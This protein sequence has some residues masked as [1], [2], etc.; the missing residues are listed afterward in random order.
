M[1]LD[2]VKGIGKVRKEQYEKIGI[3]SA[4]ALIMH[5]PLRY[6]DRGRIL[7]ITD[8]CDGE[9][10]SCMLT[11]ATAP[12]LARLTRGRN[13]VKFRAFDDSASVEI[14]FFCKNIH[15]IPRYEIGER[16][17]VYGRYRRISGSYYTENPICE[18]TDG[19]SEL[20]PLFPIYGL[21]KGLSSKIVSGH[22]R[23][24]IATAKENVCSFF[25]EYLPES[26]LKSE[27]LCT[28]EDAITKLH[29]PKTEKD[30]QV[31]GK[32][33]AF[34]E[35]L[36]YFLMMK[37][38]G[39]RSDT[40]KG[41]SM[42][43]SYPQNEIA[44]LPFSLTEDQKTT[45]E[46]IYRDLSSKF[47]MKRIVI[48]DVG[49]GKTAI[50]QFAALMVLRSG[51][52]VALMAPTEILASQH[53]E[54]LAPIFKHYGFEALLLMG[55]TSAKEKRSIREAIGDGN[56]KQKPKLLIGTHA[57][58]TKNV[59]FAEDSLKLV[60]IDEQHRFG[61]MQR[62]DLL[63]KGT[64]I[65]SLS[66]SATPI[67]RTYAKMLYG[68]YDTSFITTLPAGRLPVR[69]IRVDSSYRPRLET[70]IL[71]K[72]AEGRQVYVVCPTIEPSEDDDTE[73]KAR[74]KAISVE[75]R[76]SQLKEALPSLNIGLL[77]GKMKS[78]DK[79]EV[80]DAFK[81]KSIDVLVS[82]TVIEVG[83][84][85]PNATLMIIEGADRFGLAQLHQLRGRI[86]RSS[87]EA[88]CVLI[89][90]NKS[91]E[92]I[93]R[94][95]TLVEYS[96][97]F[98]MSKKDLE[99]RGPGDLFTMSG[100]DRSIRQSGEERFKFARFSTEEG[101]IERSFTCAGNILAASPDLSAYP[102]LSEHAKKQMA[103]RIEE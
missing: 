79:N 4:E 65:N 15:A 7:P 102:L 47:I 64:N 18:Y 81:S 80:M 51:Y 40:E 33:I 43:I 96:S 69:T 78:S 101:M 70:F 100:S 94:L 1:K 39:R 25:E 63:E 27:G 93:S 19:R 48:G 29:F 97:G 32:S 83:V 36:T 84:N 37:I 53:H 88:Y 68:D 82:T 59:V 99:A 54:T 2:E 26:V 17:R 45:L 24:A 8:A 41:Y 34:R 55:S 86:A 89:S 30:V 75:E 56:S 3:T 58:I 74:I 20:L 72:V 103:T 23:S 49:C 10:H 12:R 66:L 22:V 11:V 95:D 61:V 85:V 42:A 6:E 92:A 44:E 46:E 60:I 9:K 13:I 77:H 52:S 28:F 38:N 87:Y 14:S 5:L 67:P 76:Y 71:K 57:L 73:E 31:G 35:F 21:S 98:D 62:Q 91:K 50:A 16:L 90:D